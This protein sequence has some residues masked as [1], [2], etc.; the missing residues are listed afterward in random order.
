MCSQITSLSM[1]QLHGCVTDTDSQFV[2]SLQ[3]CAH[4]RVLRAP[5]CVCETVKLKERER[6]P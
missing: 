2:L 1:C 6:E 4:V 3:V 5:V